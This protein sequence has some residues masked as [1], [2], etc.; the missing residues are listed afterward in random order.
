MKKV[1]ISVGLAVLLLWVSNPDMEA[2]RPFVRDVA[3]AEIAEAT[4]GGT[5]GRVL[6]GAGSELVA[7]QI[8]RVTTRNSYLVCSTYRVDLDRDGAAEWEFLGIATTFVTLKRP[9]RTE[10]PADD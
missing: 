3:Q 9:T 2:F 5:L 6:G 4:G 7:S 10:R 1:P 8:D